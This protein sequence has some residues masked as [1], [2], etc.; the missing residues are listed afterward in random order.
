MLPNFQRRKKNKKPSSPTSPKTP[1]SPTSPK[2]P[3]S[4]QKEEEEEEEDGLSKDQFVK[5]LKHIGYTGDAET[6]FHVLDNDAKG[7]VDEDDLETIEEQAVDWKDSTLQ[8]FADFLLRYRMYETSAKA[9]A[10][11]FG[12]GPEDRINAA[13]FIEA[14]QMMTY[15]GDAR[16]LFKLLDQ[17]GDERVKLADLQRDLDVS[18]KEAHRRRHT[19][20]HN[21]DLSA[22]SPS[23]PGVFEKLGQDRRRTS[24][25]FEIQQFGGRRST[26]D[27]EMKHLGPTC[28][29]KREHGRRRSAYEMEL[30]RKADA[31]RAERSVLVNERIEQKRQQREQERLEEERLMQERL[32]RRP[33]KDSNGRKG[34]K[35][36]SG[37]GRSST[38]NLDR[39]S[40]VKTGSK[41]SSKTGSKE[42]SSF[43]SKERSGT[44]DIRRSLSKS[45]GSKDTV[46]TG[47]KDSKDVSSIP[48]RSSNMRQGSKESER[49]GSKGSSK[50][51]FSSSK[52]QSGR[53]GSKESTERSSSVPAESRNQSKQST[54]RSISFS[55]GVQK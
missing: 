55:A 1:K 14:L 13:D 41:D 37:H 40:S 28:L 34:S 11:G 2:T 10:E 39:R 12:K 29:S 33:S 21:V 4:P 44:K 5:I 35:D 25:Q 48:E 16:M 53:R 51:S 15:P 27:L 26:L 50:V 8:F 7:F 17:D 46:R 19:L 24:L 52:D 42:R 32:E 47:S 6:A 30:Q 49:Q 43:G 23:N 38:K 31:R 45:Q 36:L 18:F 22:V 20:E 9:Y 54:R 3:K